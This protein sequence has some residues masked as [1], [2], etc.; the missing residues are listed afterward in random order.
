MKIFLDDMRQPPDGTWAVCRTARE[1]LHF[2]ELCDV[3]VISLDHDLG[4]G[5]PTGYDVCKWIECK[6][7]YDDSYVPPEMKIHSAN[8]VGRKNMKAAIESINR[9]RR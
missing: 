7:H 8:P 4:D 9:F 3:S 6:V 1:A 5:V 2:L